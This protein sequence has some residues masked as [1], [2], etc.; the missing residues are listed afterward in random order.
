MLGI[1]LVF[2]LL[3]HAQHGWTGQWW[4]LLPLLIALALVMVMDLRS[5]IIPDV[6]TLPGITYAL[7]L[8][9]GF[10]GAA[11]FV[12]GGLGALAGGA[13]V[14]LLAIVSR[15]VLAEGISS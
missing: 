7:L 12:E 9:A 11:G 1:A 13:M 6:I 8:A 4:A 15:E 3:A 14:L 10:R 2:V 5:R